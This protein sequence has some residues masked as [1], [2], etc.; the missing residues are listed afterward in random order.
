MGVGSPCRFLGPWAFRFGVLCH[1][2][3]RQSVPRAEFMALITVVERVALASLLKL[4]LTV[5]LLCNAFRVVGE[6]VS[7]AICG[8]AC[9]L[10]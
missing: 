1:V 8:I 3:G 10:L 9:G 5:G 2:P 4:S 6:V 7:M